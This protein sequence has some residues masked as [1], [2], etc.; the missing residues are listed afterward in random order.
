MQSRFNAARNQLAS[1]AT[2][3]GS[4]IGAIGF[5]FDGSVVLDMARQGVE[6][7][8]VA[9]FHAGLPP[10]GASAAPGK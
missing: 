10:S 2:V 1:H 7:R 6:L 4:R 5:C 8:G 9:A 3:D